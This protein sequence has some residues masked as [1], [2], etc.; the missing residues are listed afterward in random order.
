M[1]TR[2]ME[3]IIGNLPMEKDFQLHYR[4]FSTF[5]ASVIFLFPN[6]PLNGL[7]NFPFQQAKRSLTQQGIAHT[8]LNNPK[9][10]F[11]KALADSQWSK[12]W[13][14]ISHTLFTQITPINHNDMPLYINSLEHSLSNI[15]SSVVVYNN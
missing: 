12:R 3:T 11:H 5:K 13:L 10:E 1:E 14:T 4:L 2:N 9:I 15:I 7:P 6:A 8:K